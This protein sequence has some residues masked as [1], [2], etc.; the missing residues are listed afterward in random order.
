MVVETSGQ[1]ESAFQTIMRR[2]RPIFKNRKFLPQVYIYPS[3]LRGSGD[4]V[5]NFTS[6]KRDCDAGSVRIM[7]F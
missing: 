5:Q 1:K 3:P 7:Q 6:A 2:S 4:G